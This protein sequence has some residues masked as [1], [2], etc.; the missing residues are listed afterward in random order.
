MGACSKCG[1]TGVCHNGIH[2]TDGFRDEVLNATTGFL[3][4]CDECGEGADTPG[5]CGTC[6]GSG[7]YGD[8]E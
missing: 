5:N 1:G 7:E 3:Y 4:T 8:D 6:N 2:R